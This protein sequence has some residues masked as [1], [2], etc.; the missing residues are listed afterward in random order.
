[1][2][3]Q[4]RSECCVSPDTTSREVTGGARTCP[5][6]TTSGRT[7]GEVV[8]DEHEHSCSCVHKVEHRGRAPEGRCEARAAEVD[9]DQRLQAGAALQRDPELPPQRAPRAVTCS[10]TAESA[11]TAA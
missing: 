3:S 6:P 4:Q 9:I 1:M 11:S 7:A 2:M 5:D 8:C 10:H